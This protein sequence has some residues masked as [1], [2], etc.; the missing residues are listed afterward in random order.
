[1]ITIIGFNFLLVQ[2][3]LFGNGAYCT[4]LRNNDA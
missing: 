1:M 2:F 3:Q 4:E